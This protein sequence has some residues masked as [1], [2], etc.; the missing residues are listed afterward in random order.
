[1]IGINKVI[2]V[3][4]L[5]KDPEVRT[6]ESGTKTATFS[7]ATT[8]VWKNKEGEKKELTEWHNIVVWRGL[9]DV[10]EKYVKKGQLLYIEGKIR[11]RSY[12]KDGQKKYITEVH[13]DGLQMLSSKK[14]TN[15]PQEINV[16]ASNT[17]TARKPEDDDL[18]F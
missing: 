13:A 4:H 12:E 5:G 18:P 17:D 3:G 14:D 9:A 15:M 7:L 8:E 11:T 16:E 10:V 1:M 2:L 6:L